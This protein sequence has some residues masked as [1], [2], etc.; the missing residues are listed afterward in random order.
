MADQLD[1]RTCDAYWHNI[2]DSSRNGTRFATSGDISLCGL[3]RKI[4]SPEAS[5]M[6]SK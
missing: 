1:G 2:S 5:Q 3:E 4:E 6:E